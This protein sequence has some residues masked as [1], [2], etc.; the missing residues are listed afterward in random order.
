[1]PFDPSIDDD[2]AGWSNPG[3]LRITIH[4]QAPSNPLVCSLRCVGVGAADMKTLR[5]RL[6][7]RRPHPPYQQFPGRNCGRQRGIETKVLRE[8]FAIE[9]RGPIGRLSKPPSHAAPIVGREPLRGRGRITK[10]RIGDRARKRPWRIGN[11]DVATAERPDIQQ[12]KLGT[13]LRAARELAQDVGLQCPQ[14]RP[15]GKAIR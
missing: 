5:G 1:M 14:L 13:D 4:P 11:R 3:P 7:L 10:Y 2:D 6:E 15:V 9:A 8:R 12:A